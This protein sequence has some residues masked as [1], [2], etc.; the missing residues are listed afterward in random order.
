MKE[1]DQRPFRV[2]KTEM[3]KSRRIFNVI[4]YVIISITVILSLV[5]FI[6]VIS[7]S[8]SEN[9]QIIRYGYSIFPRGF[10]LDG[11]RIIFHFPLEIGRAY[12]VSIFVTACGTLIGL[13]VTT[14]AGYA[15][16]C[17]DLR[18]GPAIAFFIYFTMLFSGGVVP[19]YMVIVSLGL[20]ETLWSL[21]LP[22]TGNAFYILMTRNFM[23]EIPSALVESAKI[24]G[25]GDFLVFRKIMI[26]LSKP[27]IATVGLFLA[28]AYWN[29]WYHASLFV[30]DQK[31]WP[32]QYRLYKILSAQSSISQAGAENL[33]VTS[34]PTE[35]MKLANAVVA[36][37]PIVLL[38]P[39]LQKY[40]VQGIT[41]GAVKG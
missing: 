23:R 35:A 19:W 14:M 20:K 25:A 21:I 15:L 17:R 22:M 4:A 11:Y 38:Y 33:P 34:I 10:S 18:Y 5:P 9:S 28:L 41:I 8:F 31:M 2:V 39:F 6:M 32:L 36:T 16:Q 26:P 7:G 13:L 24:D 37:G 30:K 1:Q 12:F 29:D 3:T 40:F 27:V